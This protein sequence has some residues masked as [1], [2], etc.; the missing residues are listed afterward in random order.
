MASEATLRLAQKLAALADEHKGEDITILDVS[1][2]HSLIDCFV[3]ITA[4]GSKHASTIGEEAYRYVKAQGEKPWHREEASD[5]ICCDFSDVVVHVFTP[6]A[7][8]YYDFGSLWADAPR[9]TWSPATTGDAI[10][11]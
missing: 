2:L 10:P 4:N 11:A 3:V 8:R 7:R 1:E 5:W 9:I 6:E